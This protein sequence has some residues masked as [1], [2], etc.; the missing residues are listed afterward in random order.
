M[1]DFLLDLGAS[2][3]RKDF[4][5]S[6]LHVSVVAD[7]PGIAS[8]LVLERHID[9]I[10]RIQTDTPLVYSNSSPSSTEETIKQHSSLGANVSK[11][12]AYYG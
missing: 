11:I 8:R 4:H 10:S 9:V 2:L 7:I 6:G 3:Q 1:A 5:F 12:T